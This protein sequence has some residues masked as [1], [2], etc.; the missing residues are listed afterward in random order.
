GEDHYPYAEFLYHEL[1][2]NSYDADATEV[3]ILEETVVPA[4]PGRSPIYNITIRDNGIGMDEETL[5]EWFR[6]G[7]SSKPMKKQSELF[8]RPLIGQIGVGKVAILK[9]AREW[10]I[11]TERHH[12]RPKPQRL[13]VHVNVDEWISGRVQSFEI[14]EIPPEG[15]PGTELVL[16]GVRTKMRTDRIVRHIQRLPLFKDDFKVRRN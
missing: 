7:E 12:G 5:P 2:A 8:E 1:A 3:E 14:E 16:L 15:R 11:T 6:L 10:T 4:G 9:V 13:R